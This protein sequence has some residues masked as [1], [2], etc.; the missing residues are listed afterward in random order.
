MRPWLEE[1]KYVP[2]K[3]I[4]GNKINTL[5]V[6]SCFVIITNTL[7]IHSLILKVGYIHYANVII[8]IK[9]QL[10]YVDKGTREFT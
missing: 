9:W 3:L 6:M 5:T 8:I 2:T 4:I 7:N 1:E 10:V